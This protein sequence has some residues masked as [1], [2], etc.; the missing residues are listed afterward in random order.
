[1]HGPADVID[2]FRAGVQAN[3]PG[4]EIYFAHKKTC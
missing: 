4:Y 2:V 3:H 1:M